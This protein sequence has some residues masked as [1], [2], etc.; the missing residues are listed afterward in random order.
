[1]LQM[2]DGGD[3]DEKL[4]CVPAKDPRYASVTKLDAN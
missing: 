3:P 2:I 1:M 4:L